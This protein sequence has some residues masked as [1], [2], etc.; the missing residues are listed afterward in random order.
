MT[1]LFI[2]FLAM[3]QTLSAALQDDT[4]EAKKSLVLFQE[5]KKLLKLAPKTEIVKIFFSD[6]ITEFNPRTVSSRIGTLFEDDLTSNV[7]TSYF[8]PTT[9]HSQAVEDSK[10]RNISLFLLKKNDMQSIFFATLAL[11]KAKPSHILTYLFN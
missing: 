11:E 9:L 5:T 1:K 7:E 4:I 2:L 3:T 6:D 8:T 10:S